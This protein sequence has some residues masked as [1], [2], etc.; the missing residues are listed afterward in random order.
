MFGELMDSIEDDFLSLVENC[1]TTNH[2]HD[3]AKAM[4][5]DDYEATGLQ[6]VEESQP[7]L[8][9]KFHSYFKDNSANEETTQGA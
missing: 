2:F 8:K 6:I 5:G 1:P 4:L 9:E 7:G 3:T